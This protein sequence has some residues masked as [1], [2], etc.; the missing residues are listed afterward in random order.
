MTSCGRNRGRELND[1]DIEIIDGPNIIP[2]H[3]RWIY[4]MDP[5]YNVLE[6]ILR[7]DK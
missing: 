7:L 4:F 3:E 6:Y 2:E 1:N 5:D